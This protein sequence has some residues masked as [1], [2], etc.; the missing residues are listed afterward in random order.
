MSILLWASI[1]GMV[2]AITGL[3][4]NQL[5]YNYRVRLLDQIHDEARK[6]IQA[7]RDWEWRHQIFEQVTYNQ[8]VFKFWKPLSSFYPDKS[9]INPKENL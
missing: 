8:M 1:P 9:F 2:V 4:R 3:I 7:G 6:D 5:V